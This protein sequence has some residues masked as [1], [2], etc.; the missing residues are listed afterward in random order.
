LNQVPVYGTWNFL[1][2]PL[3]F[4]KVTAQPNLGKIKI[5]QTP[6]FT[7]LKRFTAP[8]I[9]AAVGAALTMVPAGPVCAQD[10]TTTLAGQLHDLSS[11][12][13]SSGDATLKSLGGEL[14]TKARSLDTSLAG[15]PGT[16]TQLTGA[17]QSLLGNKG[18]EAVAE[19]QKLSAAKL[20]PDQMKLAKDFGHVGSAYLVQKN[21]GALDGSQSDVAQIV[22]SLRSGNVTAALPAIKKVSQNANLTS[23]QKDLL[24]SMAD[25]LVPGVG[26]A[27]DALN[28]GLKSLPGFGH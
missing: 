9:C 4:I 10:S 13:Q 20:T 16:Q 14:A 2:P 23:E 19:F 22:S 7:S 24:T 28:S 8:L 26:K 27:G 6:R 25:K 11:A 18:P 21:L 3:Y 1:F 12:S 5:M 17:L 15:S